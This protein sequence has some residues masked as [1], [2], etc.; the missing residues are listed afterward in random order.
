MLFAKDT[1][2]NYPQCHLR[3]ARFKGVDKTEFLD[4]RQAYGNAFV[5]LNEAMEF[6]FRHLPISGRFEPEKLERID[7]LLF[8]PAALREAL[9]NGLCHR[10][11]SI[12]GGALSVAILMIGWKSG[13]L[14]VS[15]LAC[16]QGI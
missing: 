7:E 9:V 11:Y 15:L 12:Y 2:P 16:E 10:D 6:L 13:V 5:L 8:P 3:L 1:F 4:N 14:G